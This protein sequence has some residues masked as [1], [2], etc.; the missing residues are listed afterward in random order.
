MGGM[1]THG[2]Q[3]G[4]RARPWPT[5]VALVAAGSL[6]G[7]TGGGF[8]LPAPVGATEGGE[9]GIEIDAAPDV[10]AEL[11][12]RLVLDGIDVTETSCSAGT[13]VALT[14]TG[15]APGDYDV[16]VDGVPEG[17]RTTV[18]CDDIVATRSRTPE[19]VD[20]A[21]MWTC[22]AFVGTPAVLLT[23]N[24][25]SAD[26][27]LDVG[28]LGLVPVTG[29]TSDCVDDETNGSPAIRCRDLPLGTHEVEVSEAPDTA[30][31]RRPDCASMVFGADLEYA[32]GPA[33]ALTEERWLWWCDVTIEP[34]AIIGIVAV[35]GALPDPDTVGLRVTGNGADVTSRCSPFG[36]AGEPGTWYWVCDLDI[37]V[38]E[39]DVGGVGA[40]GVLDA[41][42]G[43]EV[44]TD[45]ADPVR[46]LWTLAAPTPPTTAPTTAPPANVLPRTGAS[47]GAV[48]VLAV[49][50][51]TAG[52]VLL[53]TLRPR[54]RRP[55]R[56]A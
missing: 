18:N 55:S 36:S 14:C 21:S 49:S 45:L 28:V 13:D 20:S 56:G 43:F 23:V 26:P 24:S 54:S 42:E 9:I 1:T 53:L 39:V 2:E 7:A 50:T 4:S 33:G 38:Y 32:V 3:S 5:T 52:V 48:G 10:E 22:T 25:L 44:T 47:P 16:E 51:L 6:V 35:D 37:G 17:L 41:C 12:V 46:C 8:A 29:V 34:P 31:V 30:I 15:L 19:I 27:T 40:A 11:S